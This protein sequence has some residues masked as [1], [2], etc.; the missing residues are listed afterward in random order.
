MLDTF[1]DLWCA[2]Q[3]FLVVAQFFFIPRWL[4]PIC[5]GTQNRMRLH[6]PVRE[7]FPRGALHTMPFITVAPHGG[8][9]TSQAT[10]T[11]V[12]PSMQV[13]TT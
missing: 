3:F 7:S 10:A 5:D 8:L 4:G 6:N 11:L 9:G 1:W 13:A 2:N 12:S